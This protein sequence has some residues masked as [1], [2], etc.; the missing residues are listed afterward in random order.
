MAFTLLDLLEHDNIYRVKTELCV[1]DSESTTGSVTVDVNGT[2]TE[3]TVLA[4][5]EASL[6]DVNTVIALDR[7]GSNTVTITNTGTVPV[8]IQQVT[9]SQAKR[10]VPDQT[11]VGWYTSE[12]AAIDAADPTFATGLASALEASDIAELKS[13]IAGNYKAFFAAHPGFFHTDAE[14]V[15]SRWTSVSVNGTELVNEDPVNVGLIIQSGETVVYD[16]AQFFAT[17]T[18]PAGPKYPWDPAYIASK[19][20]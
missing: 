20:V 2:V 13:Y 1:M 3:Q 19:T 16:L 12:K 4:V 9:L 17:A 15:N 18:A 8:K 5:R 10:L 11:H 14:F 6:D 7:T